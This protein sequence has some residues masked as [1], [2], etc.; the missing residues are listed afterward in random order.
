MRDTYSSLT[1]FSYTHQNSPFLKLPGEIR[2]Q[3]YTYFFAPGVGFTAL[4]IILKT[5]RIINIKQVIE[6]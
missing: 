3:I 4:D 5:N 2:N 6:K 1:I